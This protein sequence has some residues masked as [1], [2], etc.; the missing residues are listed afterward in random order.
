[1]KTQI[2]INANLHFDILY[3]SFGIFKDKEKYIEDRIEF[4]VKQKGKLY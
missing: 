4:Y 1:M 2:I 3:F